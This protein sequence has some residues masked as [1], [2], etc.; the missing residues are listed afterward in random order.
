MKK[1]LMLLL[2]IVTAVSFAPNSSIGT[3]QAQAA[4]EESFNTEWFGANVLVYG[5]G[6]E[7]G[8]FAAG[9]E[10]PDSL[11]FHWTLAANGLLDSTGTFKRAQ[12]LEEYVDKTFVTHSDLEEYF[13]TT[14]NDGFVYDADSDSITLELGGGGGDPVTLMTYQDQTENGTGAIY[15]RW[16]NAETEE[17][18]GDADEL[19]MMAVDAGAEDFIEEDDSFTILTDPDDFSAVREALEQEKRQRLFKD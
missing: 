12:F 17:Y 1:F 15:C 3:V 6:Y 18:E 14:Q 10:A 4:E 8:Y 9:E 16:Y 19:M 7:S 11:V 13:S 5:G 2:A